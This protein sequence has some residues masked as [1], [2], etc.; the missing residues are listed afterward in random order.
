MCVRGDGRGI[1]RGWDVRLPPA[2]RA[3]RRSHGASHRRL[4][5]AS[6]RADADS[7][8]P[9]AGSAPD[10]S[11]A[12]DAP[13]R[14]VANGVVL[15]SIP[16]SEVPSHQPSW[17]GQG[18]SGGRARRAPPRAPCRHATCPLRERRSRRSGSCSNLRRATVPSP[19]GRPAAPLPGPLTIGGGDVTGRGKK[20]PRPDDRDRGRAWAPSSGTGLQPPSGTPPLKPFFQRWTRSDHCRLPPSSSTIGVPLCNASLKRRASS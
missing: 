16:K 1:E 19:R 17:L 2:T 7:D 20:Q 10:Q 13:V 5:A 11:E 12:G 9:A 18:T 15:G 8:R 6:G 4:W 14:A 3:R